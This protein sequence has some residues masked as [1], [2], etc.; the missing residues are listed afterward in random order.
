VHTAAICSAA[1]GTCRATRRTAATNCVMVSCV[2]TAS[3]TIVESTARRCRPRKIPVSST[4]LR[5]ASLMRCGR[6][7]FANRR[8][9][10]VNVDG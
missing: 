4:T 9:Q 2:A 6:A 7:D 8:R 10:Y 3:A 5:T 1:P